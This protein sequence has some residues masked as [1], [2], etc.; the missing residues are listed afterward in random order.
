MTTPPTSSK[1]APAE[2]AAPVSTADEIAT[3]RIRYALGIPTGD[4]EPPAPRRQV[5]PPPTRLP[6][7]LRH[8]QPHQ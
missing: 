2:P 3:W 8:G 6:P 4:R 5:A 7:A 1:I